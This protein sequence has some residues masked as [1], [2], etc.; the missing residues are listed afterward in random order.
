MEEFW[1]ADKAFETRRNN[2]NSNSKPIIKSHTQAFHTSR[3]LDFTERLNEHLS[4]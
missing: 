3:L 4:K 1:K 2:N